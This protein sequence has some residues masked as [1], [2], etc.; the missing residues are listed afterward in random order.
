[1]L[2]QIFQRQ[3]IL[4]SKVMSLPPGERAFLFASTML[5]IEEY[6]KHKN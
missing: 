4:P 1:L 2:H 3:G 5:R 6:Q